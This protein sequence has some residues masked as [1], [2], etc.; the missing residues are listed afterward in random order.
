MARGGVRERS[1]RV[2]AVLIAAFILLTA[3]SMWL[4]PGVWLT[5]TEVP[6]PSTASFDC[7]HRAVE[8]VPELS[9]ISTDSSAVNARLV[10]S[11]GGIDVSRPTSKTFRVRDGGPQWPLA[12]DPS[13][14]RH[15]MESGFALKLTRQHRN[16]SDY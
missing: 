8:R 13:R 5:Q 6:V 3:F 2:A 4:V 14:T 12:F 1:L 16:A 10:S 9:D 15:L 7:V 11:R